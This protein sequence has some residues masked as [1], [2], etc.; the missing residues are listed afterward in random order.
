MSGSLSGA[1]GIASGG[2]SNISLGIA[3][4]SQNVANAST[5]QYALETATQTSQSADGQEFGVRS[6]LV[7]RATD[8]GLQSQVS[9]QTSA[10]AAANTTSAALA[11]IEPVLGT[12]GAG[13]DLGS[14]LGSVQS[15]FATL[16]GDPADVTQQGVVLDAAAGLATG[17]NTLAGAYG[18]ARQTAQDGVVSGIGQLNSAL[19]SLG[20][21]S[22]QIVSLKSQGL[23]TADLENQRAQVEATISGLVDTRFLPQPNGDVTVLTAG[24]AQLP[25]DGTRL[26][27]PPASTGPTVS[28]AGGGIP[29]VTLDGADITGQLTGGS[30]GANIALRDQVLPTYQAG[31]DEFAETLSSRFAAQ[32]LTLFSD[33]TGQVPASTGPVAQ[34][35]Y[36]GYAQTI[37][38]NPAVAAQPAL[39]RD[40]TNAVAGSP[41]GASAFTPNTGGLPGFTT[42]VSRILTYA[43]G[44][45]V[46]DGV[47]QA[48]VAS[49]GLGPTGTLSTGL[50][51]QG[52]LTDAANTLTASQAADSAAATTQAGDTQAVQTAL[53][54]KLTAATGVD[55]DTELG[56]MVVLQNAYGANAKIISAVQA[57]FQDVLNMVNP[58]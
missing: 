52:S 36:V 6:G 35:G 17:I 13:T 9:S 1:L 31:L 51:V 58:T 38:V 25:T 34:S 26:L 57:L 30:I 41:A 7:I 55:M 33:A 16:L 20:T 4:I 54:G 22:T 50:G 43:L 56:Q 5:P 29:A 14:L 10:L 32:G 44:N 27:A 24:G 21:L 39:L 40:G 12:V 46:Q 49:T 2:L 47:P 45:D 42:L 18:A 19:A 37:Q 23:S 53:Q 8:P 11:T 28:Y 48:A 3:V 15:G